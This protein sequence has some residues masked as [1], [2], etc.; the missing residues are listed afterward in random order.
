MSFSLQCPLYLEENRICLIFYDGI[1][2]VVSGLDYNKEL[3]DPYDSDWFWIMHSLIS[4]PL[5]V[6]LLTFAIEFVCA[7]SPHQMKGLLC[8]QMT[9]IMSNIVANIIAGVFHTVCSDPRYCSIAYSSMATLWSVTGFVLLEIL[10]RWYKMRV[11]DDIATPHRWV[12][13]AYE[14]YLASDNHSF[15]STLY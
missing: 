11:R 9:I 14:K 8:G 10:S 1:S 6:I 3:T 13:D 4:A 5:K 2:L 15:G 12:E 7:Q